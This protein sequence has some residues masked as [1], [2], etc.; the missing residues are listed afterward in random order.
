MQ[1]GTGLRCALMMRAYVVWVGSALLPL[2][3]AT[4]LLTLLSVCF[5]PQPH[6]H[7]L[8]C[9]PLSSLL[10]VCW[11]PFSPSLFLTASADWSVRLWSEGQG[12]SLWAFQLPSS[13]AEVADVAFCPAAA[14]LFAAAVGNT[15]QLWDVERSVLAPAAT[16]TRFGTRLTALAFSQ[17]GGRQHGQRRATGAWAF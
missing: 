13:K 5:C 12:C 16:A 10:Q 8:P 15:L 9:P 11:S 14:T 3:A 6:T 2:M 17:V 1:E 7:L 4:L